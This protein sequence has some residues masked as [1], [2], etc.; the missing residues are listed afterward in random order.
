MAASLSLYEAGANSL[1]EL[2]AKARGLRSPYD[3][4]RGPDAF[5]SAR[6]TVAKALKESL[7]SEASEFVRQA[8]CLLALQRLESVVAGELSSAVATAAGEAALPALSQ[9]ITQLNSMQSAGAIEL[10][11][12]VRQSSAAHAAEVQ[13]Q[14]EQLRRAERESSVPNVFASDTVRT[15]RRVPRRERIAP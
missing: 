6:S 15:V 2:F 3:V 8:E 14:A 12:L 7:A 11:Q 13:A 9:L 1:C 4:T 10:G 5:S